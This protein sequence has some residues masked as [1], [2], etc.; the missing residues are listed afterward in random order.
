MVG[1]VERTTAWQESNVD[2]DGLNIHYYRTGK[3]FKPQLV[4]AHGF[5]D[6][7]LCWRRVA[8]DLQDRFDVI[9]VDARNHGQSGTAPASS[10]VLIE[11]LAGVITALSLDKPA[12]LGHSMG[13]S[14]VAGVA[15]QYPH[16]VSK[17]ILEDPLWKERTRPES[18]ADQNTRLQAYQQQ[19]EAQ[20]ALSSKEIIQAGKVQHPTWRDDEFPDWEIAKQQV[21]AEAMLGLSVS[22]WA[23]TLEVVTRISC[24]SLL[25][26]AET[27]SDGVVTAEI[28][29]KVVESNNQFRATD[30]PGAG[31]NIRREG[32]DEYLTTLNSFLN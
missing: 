28:A 8:N 30:I 23:E 19:L 24:P 4:V 29:T 9:M 6:N 18:A 26:R 11:D 1:V 16:L 17:I 5:G 10:A 3:N 27:G 13:A 7:G 20:Q 2:L 15:A 14:T 32:F 21:R 25:I 12:L 22:N 31:H